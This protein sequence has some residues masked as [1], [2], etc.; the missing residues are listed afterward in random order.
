[1][2]DYSPPP[3]AE[4]IAE[5]L[6]REQAEHDRQRKRL[7]D[8]SAEEVKRV[9]LDRRESQAARLEALSALLSRRDPGMPEILLGLLDEPE[10]DLWLSII[11]SYCPDDPRVLGRLRT[12]L[13]DPRDRVWSEA[14]CALARRHDPSILPR[15][16]GWF[17]DGDESHRNVAI[18]CLLLLGDDE[19]LGR[20]AEEFE[21]GGRDDGDRVVLALAL[22]RSGDERGRPFLEAV[23]RRADGAWSVAAA[24]WIWTR[25]PAEGLALMRHILDHG[26]LEARRA[27]VSQVWNFTELPHALTADGIHEARAWVEQRQRELAD[28]RPGFGVGPSEGL[29]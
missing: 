18:E 2:S 20:I 28:G 21:R 19:A 7:R 8:A 1:M 9:L 10:P 29:R 22:L 13:D 27:M 12:F 14:A 5:H 6:H 16:L 23:A 17:R 25:R 26:T 24:S 15:A 3:G 4:R 11:H